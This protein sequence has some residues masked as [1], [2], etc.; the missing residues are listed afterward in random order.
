MD[1]KIDF[2]KGNLDEEIY[3]NQ[4]NGFVNK[5]K[6]KLVCKLKKSLYGLSKHPING[7][8]YN[9][10]SSYSYEENLLTNVFPERIVY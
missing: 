8:Y 9:V 3:M 1:V 4:P 10:I 6:V 2:L 5:E 7:H